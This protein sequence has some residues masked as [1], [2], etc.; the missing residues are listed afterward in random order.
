M[1][2][3]STILPRSGAECMDAGFPLS[4]ICAPRL[5]GL[6]PLWRDLMLDFLH[7]NRPALCLRAISIILYFQF[8]GK[9]ANSCLIVKTCTRCVFII[10]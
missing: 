9:V 8:Q 5:G 6:F 10:C 3:R 1:H 2:R 7:F 4:W